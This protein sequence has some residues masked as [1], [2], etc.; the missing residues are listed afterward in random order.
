MSVSP[1]TTT[2]IKESWPWTKLIILWTCLAFFSSLPYLAGWAATPSGEH[3]LGRIISAP[4]DV[5][6]YYS[7]LVQASHGHLLFQNNFTAEPQ[8]A[9]LFEP[10]WLVGGW[11]MAIFRLS[12][13]IMFHALRVAAIFPFLMVL[14]MWAKKFT[15]SN[16]RRWMMLL[17]ATTSSGLGWLSLKI[18]SWP[19]GFDAWVA[20]SNSFLTM[21][22]SAL[23]LLSQA[24]LAWLILRAWETLFEGKRS[25]WW[26][27][28]AAVLVLAHP[29]DAITLGA[30]IAVFCLMT[31][32]QKNS[33]VWAFLLQGLWM[34]PLGLYYWWALREPALAGW[35]DQNLNP[36]GP[37]LRFVIGYAWMLLFGAIGAAFLL[38]QQKR[39][40][41]AAIIW[42]GAA[43]ILAYLPWIHFQRRLVNG[44]GIPFTM[45]GGYAIAVLLQ[46]VRHFGARRVIAVAVV[47][48]LAYTNAHLIFVTSAHLLK[49]NPPYPANST[50]DEGVILRAI[51]ERVP[52]QQPI[53]APEWLGN[54]I[55]GLTG[56]TVVLGHDQQTI[57]FDQKEAQWTM[58]VDGQGTATERQAAL[59]E[60]GAEWMVW[61]TKNSGAYQPATDSTWKAVVATP[62]L[63]LYQRQPGA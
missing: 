13:V 26:G 57:H 46:R 1:G 54:D 43:A 52:D 62:T 29:Y 51:R 59:D 10:I 41:W 50:A 24:L 30:V 17:I 36:S 34:V 4:G 33:Q 31:M 3:Y 38:R 11:L 18:P 37:F 14:W 35:T 5:A 42:I 20:E 16:E 2:S 61:E 53:A 12:P 21:T 19:L 58:Y 27:V 55:A 32:W 28:W 7:N 56:K 49:G 40:V 9:R 60:L 23:F 63:I 8:Q 6:A 47:G 44:L 45:I 48:L 15:A 39:I 25:R 22:H